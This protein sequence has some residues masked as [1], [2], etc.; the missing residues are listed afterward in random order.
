MFQH[1]LLYTENK[2]LVLPNELIVHSIDVN[3]KFTQIIKERKNCLKTEQ[4][5]PNCRE[6]CNPSG[7]SPIHLQFDASIDFYTFVS[8]KIAIMCNIDWAKNADENV[9]RSFTAIAQLPCPLIC[10]LDTAIVS[11]RRANSHDLTTRETVR[12]G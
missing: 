3:P 10:G 2:N 8:R 9:R 1:S 12:G 5:M 7:F 6:S 11:R 4:R